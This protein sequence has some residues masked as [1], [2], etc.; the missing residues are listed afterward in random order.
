MT[1]NLELL[2]F[3]LSLNITDRGQR[4]RRHFG[5]KS[6]SST[7][8]NRHMLRAHTHTT[9]SLTS[10]L[11]F[12][13][14]FLFRMAASAHISSFDSAV[15]Q[16]HP[17]LVHSLSMLPHILWLSRPLSSSCPP[18]SLHQGQPSRSP[19]I[20]LPIDSEFLEVGTGSHTSLYSWIL[21][22]A[23]LAHSQS[24]TSVLGGEEERE[25]HV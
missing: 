16:T 13:L 17:P 6:H 11:L 12:L 9:H 18:K 22:R 14:S 15:P 5:E 24:S 3:S 25:S 23:S 8:A 2:D 1:W 4:W 10:E 21:Q 7:H 20:A 19:Q